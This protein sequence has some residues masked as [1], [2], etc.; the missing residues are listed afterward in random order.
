MWALP[1]ALFDHL[2]RLLTLPHPTTPGLSQG[3]LKKRVHVRAPHPFSA[4]SWSCHGEG[5]PYGYWDNIT[6]PPR[7]LLL[8]I[9]LLTTFYRTSWKAFQDELSA[10]HD[11]IESSPLFYIPD[12]AQGASRDFISM[13]TFT[14]QPVLELI[15]ELSGRT[16]P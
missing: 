1:L 10:V 2:I 11:V 6:G 7:V 4:L 9:H 15:T 8:E 13:K 5:C 16:S 14:Y 12:E 3:R